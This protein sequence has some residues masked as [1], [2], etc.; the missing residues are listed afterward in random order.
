MSIKLLVNVSKKIPGAQGFSSTQSSVSIEGE[1]APG[2]DPVAEAARL[3]AQAQQAV[4]QFL[5]IAPVPTTA[6][7]PRQQSSQPAPSSMQSHTTRGSQP[8][9][10][11]A[12]ATD[13]QLRYIRRLAEQSGL[14]LAAIAAEQQVASLEALSCKAA[15]ALIDH[16]KTV[17]A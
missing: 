6:P 11:P 8:R 5:G 10:G 12:P 17:P 13:S 4:D 15:A 3:Q 14:S 9:R 1:L 16:L 2:Q 7:P